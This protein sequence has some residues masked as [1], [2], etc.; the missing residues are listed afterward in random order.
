[1]CKTETMPD[2]YFGALRN[3]CFD[4]RVLFNNNFPFLNHGNGI[5]IYETVNK[6]AVI[7]R[8]GYFSIWGLIDRKL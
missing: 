6:V 2:T 1:M 8:I 5:N 4:E 7:H 3:I